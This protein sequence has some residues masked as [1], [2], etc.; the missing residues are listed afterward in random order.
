M[1]YKSPNIIA[2][3]DLGEFDVWQLPDMGDAEKVLPS[4]E[5]EQKDRVARS[6]E[7]IE[8]V[9]LDES[10]ELSPITAE[11]LQ[12]I[13]EAAEKEGFT[14]GEKAGFEQG[15]KEGLEQG[16]QAGLEKAEQESRPVFEQ[17]VSQLLQVAEALIDPISHQQQQ[18]ETTVLNYV[19]SLT[20][21]LVERELLQDS[22]HIL[23]VVKQAI[24]VLP[25]GARHTTVCLNPDDLALVE[26]FSEEHGKD[27]AFRGDSQI[28]PGG[29]RIQ[30]DESLVDFTIESKL[31]A[32]FSQFL[33]RQLTSSSEEADDLL[34]SESQS[35]HFQSATAVEGIGSAETIE[36]SESAKS[37]DNDGPKNDAHS[38][39]IARPSGGASDES[40]GQAQDNDLPST[41]AASETEHNSSSAQVSSREL[42][43]G[44]PPQA[45]NVEGSNGNTPAEGF[46][47]NNPS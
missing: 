28:L 21:Q 15:Q 4:A 3:E 22:S 31:Q 39:E 43:P 9:D 41:S 23:S 36:N 1:S 37:N 14:Q 17:Q 40:L 42:D 38:A 13:T 32:M 34:S 25:V 33:D 11:E 29:C 16:Y 10:L 12:A 18:L 35:D 45:S 30:T 6:D 2:S 19:T 5:K 46:D 26:T 8:E 47:G 44:S 27:W 24:A 20:R 7:I